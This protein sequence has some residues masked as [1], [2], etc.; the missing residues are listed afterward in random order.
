MIYKIYRN[1]GR[2]DSGIW[3]I[4]NPK[5]GLV[6]AH[7]DAIIM[8][9]ATPKVSKIGRQRV[10]KEKQKNVHAFICGEIAFAENLRPFK[11]RTIKTTGF[12]GLNNK[13]EVGVTYNPY[14]KDH[15]FFAHDESEFTGAD[16]LKFGDDG[17]LH[18]LQAA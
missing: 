2:A 1:L 12:I 15:F 18:L 10:L 8:R 13:K 3:S 5:T 9:N 4:K 14:K 17:K 16:L 6:V 11:G 7:A